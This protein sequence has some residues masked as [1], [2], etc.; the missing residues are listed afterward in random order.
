MCDKERNDLLDQVRTSTHNVAIQVLL[1]IV[2]SPIRDHA[3]H[4]EEVHKLMQAGHALSALRH[5]ELVGHLIA[6]FVAFPS[7]T[8]RLPYEADGEASLS[9][10]KTNNP[11]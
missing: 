7:R 4:A 11:A 2:V 3:S 1:V 5:R 6:G 9:V 10:Y 8:I